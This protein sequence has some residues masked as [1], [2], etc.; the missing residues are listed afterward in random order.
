MTS[1]AQWRVVLHGSRADIAVQPFEATWGCAVLAPSDEAEDDGADLAIILDPDTRPA[2]PNSTTQVVWHPD[3]EGDAAVFARPWSV[4][5]DLFDV[6]PSARDDACLVIAPDASDAE[7]VVER[8]TET[9]LQVRVAAGATRELLAD[10]RVVVSLTA[11]LPPETFAVLAAGRLL[12]ARADGRS[13]GL[14]PW[15]DHL[16]FSNEDDLV[17]VAHAVAAHPTAWTPIQ[18]FGRQSA[19]PQ[20]AS[21][22]IGRLVRRVQATTATQ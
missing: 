17:E 20:R 10:A 4:A 6:P 13:F 22:A 2:S 1:D 16:P 8:L 5:D 15:I 7:A 11:G 14:Q 18:A 9:G 12:V 21:Q 3:A 19:A